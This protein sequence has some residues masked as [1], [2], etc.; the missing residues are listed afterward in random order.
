MLSRK[1]RYNRLFA[2]IVFCVKY[3]AHGIT[4]IG[5]EKIRLCPKLVRFGKN[6]FVNTITFSISNKQV[7][8]MESQIHINQFT[9]T[10]MKKEDTTR[11]PTVF[12]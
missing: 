12:R 3:T 11:L 9:C 6:L 8:Q 10:N 7:L 2:E 4:K 1:I 5:V